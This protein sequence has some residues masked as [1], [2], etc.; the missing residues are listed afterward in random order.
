M[1]SGIP[2][3]ELAWLAAVIVAGGVVAGF[4]A[5]L[6]GFA[7]FDPIKPAPTDDQP[8]VS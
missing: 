8:S 6:F 7:A 3:S 4:L 2:L 1:F 5:G